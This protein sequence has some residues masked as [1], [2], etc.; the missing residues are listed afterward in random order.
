M[1]TEVKAHFLKPEYEKAN[2]CLFLCVTNLKR[3]YSSVTDRKALQAMVKETDSFIKIADALV[4]KMYAPE[5]VYYGMYKEVLINI[6]SMEKIYGKITPE[7][8]EYIREIE[9]TGDRLLYT[10]DFKGYTSAVYGEDI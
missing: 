3:S 5:Y 6:F 10:E 9:K 4:M 2:F 8:S 7:Q 1:V